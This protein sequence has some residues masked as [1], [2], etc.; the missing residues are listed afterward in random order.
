MNHGH[1]I[2]LLITQSLEL[3][4]KLYTHTKKIQDNIGKSRSSSVNDFIAHINYL[5]IHH[6]LS[7][8]QD[9]IIKIKY[10][11]LKQR[12]VPQMLTFA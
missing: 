3:K 5:T 11:F 10:Y 9:H 12:S 8:I 7:T 2:K 1:F 4:R 6:I